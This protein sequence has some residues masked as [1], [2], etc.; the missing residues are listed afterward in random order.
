MSTLVSP[1]PVDSLYINT[2][3]KQVFLDESVASLHVFPTLLP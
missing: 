1:L 2:D 3:L